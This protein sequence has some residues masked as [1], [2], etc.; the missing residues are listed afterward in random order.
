MRININEINGNGF[1]SFKDKFTFLV[2]DYEG[3]LI[4][5]E[6]SNK[7]DERSKSNGSGKSTLLE[8]FGWGLYG[9]LCRKNKYVDE[10]INKQ[11]TYTEVNTIFSKGTDSWEVK[12]IISKKKS[13]ELII[14]KNGEGQ[15]NQATSKIKQEELEKILGMNFIAF[16]CSDMFGSDFMNFPDLKPGD[17]AKILSDIRGLG[18]YLEASKKSGETAKQIEINIQNLHLKLQKQEGILQSLRSTSYKENISEW[19]EKKKTEIKNLK[20]SI[21]PI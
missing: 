6:G 10:V 8:L 21:S 17:R 11:S 1:M 4:L 2:K 3:K 13:P 19:E 14:L 18:K 15:W 20:E 16:Q 12:R 9:E 5:V 7:D